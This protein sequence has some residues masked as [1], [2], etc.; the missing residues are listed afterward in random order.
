[1]Y[2]EEVNKREVNMLISYKSIKKLIVDKEDI[3]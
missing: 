2:M 1:M 3:M